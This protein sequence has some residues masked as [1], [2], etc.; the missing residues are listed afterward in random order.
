MKAFPIPWSHA[1]LSPT[2][3]PTP[4]PK[5]SPKTTWVDK[6]RRGRGVVNKVTPPEQAGDV[7]G[8]WQP[9]HRR[10]RRVSQSPSG[11][12]RRP[13]GGSNSN[14]SRGSE[15]QNCGQVDTEA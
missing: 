14:W 7:L 6:L 9:R 4:S 3:T 10:A 8:P 1:A 5:T 2:Q 15:G 13:L 12:H 11:R